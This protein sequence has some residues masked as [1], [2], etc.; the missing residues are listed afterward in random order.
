MGLCFCTGACKETGGCPNQWKE[1]DKYGSGSIPSIPTWPNVPTPVTPLETF[2][3]LEKNTPQMG[4][5][6]PKCSRVYSPSVFE[7]SKCNL[8]AD[9][10]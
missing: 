1:W 7:C 8:E 9:N 6:C 5:I 4:W 3:P 2:Q 10:G